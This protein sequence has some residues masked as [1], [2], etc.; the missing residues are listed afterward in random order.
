MDFNKRRH[1]KKTELNYL[2]V[3]LN[4]KHL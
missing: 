4:G 1:G 2:S 3:V